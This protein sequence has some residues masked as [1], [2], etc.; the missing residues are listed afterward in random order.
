MRVARH[1]AAH[2]LL[3]VAALAG[4]EVPFVID[5]ELARGGP[6]ER[7]TALRRRHVEAEPGAPPGLEARDQEGV[8][9]GIGLE[10]ARAHQPRHAAIRVLAQHL[11]ERGE[12]GRRAVAGTERVGDLAMRPGPELIVGRDQLVE[13]GRGREL[14]RE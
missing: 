8:V 12:V 2:Q 9:A 13:L 14:D 10:A 11:V 5:R 4:A 3:E 6:G 7:E 1:Q